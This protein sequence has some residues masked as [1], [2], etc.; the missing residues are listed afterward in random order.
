MSTLR[1]IYHLARADFYERVRRYSFL[2]ILGLSAFLGYQA[3]IGNLS[4]RLDSYRGEYNSA[5]VGSMMAVIATFFFGWFGFY[6]IKGAVGRD[7]ETGVGQIMATTPLSRPLYVIGKWFSN[8]AVL[9]AMTAILAVASVGI[10]LLAGESAQINLPALWLPFLFISIPML[11]FVAALAVLFETIGFLQGG[12]GN[13]V[14]FFLFIIFLPLSMSLDNPAFEITGMQLLEQSMGQAAKGAFPAY[15]GGFVLGAAPGSITGTFQWQGVDWTPQIILARFSLFGIVLLT[16]LLASI[17]FDRFDPSRRKPAK[18]RTKKPALTPDLVPAT[19]KSAEPTL[20]LTPLSGTRDRFRFM[21]VFTAELKLLLKGQRW[22]WYLVAGG[23]IV[24]SLVNT[25]EVTQ[26]VILP[27]AWVWP[28]LLWSSIGNREFKQGVWQL[29]FS[30]A[31]PLL[32]QLPAQWLAGFV[33]TLVMAI[34]AIVR[35]GMNSEPASLLALFA[36]AFFIPSLAL[37]L[38]VWSNSSKTFEIIYILIWYIGP[39]NRMPA[40]DYI[41]VTGESQPLYFMLAAL[42]LLA[43]AVLGRIRQLRNG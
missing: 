22:W 24:A 2:I 23:L 21:Q 27:M 1:I 36:G 13:I 7:R 29:T 28:I 26:T 14:Y 9:L 11:A 37:A 20:Q 4:I 34:G 15:D 42:V 19:V 43:F 16:L 8:M 33:L 12:F 25:S 40:L 5:W 38:G 10:Q 31:S 41:G 6:L 17:F 35:F 32:R 3:A 39:L 18:A 30:S